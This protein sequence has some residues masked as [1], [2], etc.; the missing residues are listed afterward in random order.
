VNTDK[1]S[2]RGDVGDDGFPLDVRHPFS[3]PGKATSAR[4][5][6]IQPRKPYD[7]APG[8]ASAINGRP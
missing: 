4:R 6:A 2:C 3:Q 8:G 5:L 7:R 1:W